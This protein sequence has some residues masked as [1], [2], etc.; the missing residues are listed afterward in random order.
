MS[1][2]ISKKQLNNITKQNVNISL[3]KFI[4]VIISNL[5]HFK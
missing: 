2:K 5:N 4:A 3:A 1:E